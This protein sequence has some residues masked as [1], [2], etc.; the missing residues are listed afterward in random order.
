MNRKEKAK[1]LETINL[2][3]FGGRCTGNNEGGNWDGERESE[4]GQESEMMHG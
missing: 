4:G 2:V 3:A 1:Y